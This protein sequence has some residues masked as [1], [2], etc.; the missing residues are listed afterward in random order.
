MGRVDAII[1]P[2]SK[3]IGINSFIEKAKYF[4]GVVVGMVSRSTF[5]HEVH[6]MVSLVVRYA[7]VTY[8]AIT[9]TWFTYH[10]ARHIILDR[11]IAR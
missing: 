2:K 10:F 4:Q 7:I 8:A 1:A 11:L 9:S 3:T 6:S 5:V